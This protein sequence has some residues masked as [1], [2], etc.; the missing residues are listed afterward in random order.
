M[1]RLEG[2]VALVTGAAR[3]QGRSHAVR[4]A[5]EGADL[6]LVDVLKDLP[7]LE[8]GLGTDAD[9]A[10]TVA[11]VEA[12]DRRVVWG[13][14]DVRDA[15]ALQALV[16]R[17]VGELGRLD[18]VS[19][20][21]G[22]SPRLAKLWEITPAEWDEQ[23]SVNLTGV[24]TTIRAVVPPMIAGGRGGAIVLTSSGA[25]LAGIPHL[26]AYNASKHG[27]VG[28]ALTLANELARHDIRV[29]ALCPGTVG[30]PMVTQNRAQYGVFRPDLDNPNLAD[31]M[32]ALK[33]VSP[34]G[35]PW[36]EPIDVTNALL[37]LVSDEGRYVTGITLPIDQGT[38]NRS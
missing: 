37:W 24:F 3:G 17:G 33:K 29:N 38:R 7:T 11:A 1:S 8:Y 27:V 13:Q 34:L 35:R 15:D 28:L 32:V 16:D 18:I 5:E 25:G 21:A 12:L 14:A 36:I 22:I 30:T 26:G 9:L 23:I 6:I 31:T 10:E 19:A 20:N 2:K 4:L